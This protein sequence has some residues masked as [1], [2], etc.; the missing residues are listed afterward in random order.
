M[1]IVKYPAIH[2]Y[3][4][5]D[6]FFRNAFVGKVMPRNRFQLLLRFI[7]FADEDILPK[8][9]LSKV[10]Q[11]L[12]IMEKN[13]MGA[14]I[15]GEMLVVDETMVPWR[16]RLV[17]RQYSPGKSHKYGVK[18]YKLC[19]PYGYT[20]TSS[21]YCGKDISSINRGRPTPGV[22]HSTRIVLDLAEAYLDKGRTIITDNFYTSIALANELMKRQTHL[23]GTLRTNRVGNPTAVTTAKLKK[24][25]TI[26]RECTG[27]VVA[28]WMDKREVLMLSTKH[29]LTENHTGKKNRNNEEIKKPQMIIDYNTGKQGIDLSDQMA[30]YFSPLRK[31]IRWYHKIGFEYLLNTAVVNS[32]ILYKEVKPKTKIDEFRKLIC[33]SLCQSTVSADDDIEILPGPS[34]GHKL[35]T[36]SIRDKRNRLVRK[37]CIECYRKIKN[38]ESRNDAMKKT[39][40][41]STFCNGC[42]GN[43]PL[44]LECFQQMH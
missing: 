23:L 6:T 36:Y 14:K 11:L 43:P 40:K 12:E 7:H 28:K 4:S 21:I 15:P 3:W 13:F 39:K 30:S 2:M 27:V 17:F 44:C 24:N 29:N 8:H 16:G 37:R 20:Y 5:R 33:E 34:Q 25:E 35:E 31:T 18:L 26:G 9:R 38:N 22:S 10:I 1:G 42:E 32:L 19:D 41:I